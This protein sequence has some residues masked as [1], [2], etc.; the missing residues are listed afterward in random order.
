MD[1]AARFTA[2]ANDFER[3]YADRDWAR[4]GP[5]FASDAIYECRAPEV[6]AFRVVGRAAILN[7]FETVTDAFDRGF[8]P[9]V[10]RPQ[11]MLRAL[12]YRWS[13]G[14]ICLNARGR[15]DSRFCGRTATSFGEE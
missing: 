4:L 8:P 6:L 15:S 14:A 5:Y 11:A 13:F 7:R 3:S 9:M 2:Y 10:T 1:L 12:T